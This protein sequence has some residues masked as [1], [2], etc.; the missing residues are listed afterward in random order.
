MVAAAAARKQ[1]TVRLLF[2]RRTPHNEGHGGCQ[3]EWS[4]RC[5]CLCERMA[6]AASRRPLPNAPSLLMHSVAPLGSH[7]PPGPA[8]P[9][10]SPPPP[11]RLHPCPRAMQRHPH[12][13][14][15]PH[16]GGGRSP[17]PSAGP[18]SRRRSSVRAPPWRRASACS[19]ATPLTSRGLPGKTCSA[20]ARWCAA[21]AWGCAAR[22]S[23]CVCV[24]GGGGVGSGDERGPH[25]AP[26]FRGAATHAVFA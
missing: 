25:A 14:T 9:W 1:L 15:P 26:H 10:P 13:P 18:P 12:P 6:N 7:P 3:S 19:G 17:W 22:R 8:C 23:P 20:R 16:V 21:G 5:S 2:R 4:R 24:V 11:R